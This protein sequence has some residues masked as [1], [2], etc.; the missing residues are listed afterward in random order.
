MDDN[1]L[2]HEIQQVSLIQQKIIKILEAD[3]KE[4]NPISA[5]L[6]DLELMNVATK[7]ISEKL[8]T[9]PVTSEQTF[10]WIMH[11]LRTPLTP[12]LAYTDLL[13]SNQ[14]GE[15]TDQQREKTKIIAA[16][17]K[18]LA[19]TVDSLRDRLKSSPNDT[20][21]EIRE[22]KQEKEILQKINQNLEKNQNPHQSIYAPD[23]DKLE[24]EQEKLLLSKTIKAVE[25]KN[26]R[27]GKRHVVIV[28]VFV[29]AIGAIVAGYSVYV[30]QLTGEQFRV[31]V[32][33]ANTGYVIQNL[34][35]DTIDTWLSWRLVSGAALHVNVPNSEKYP[36]KI[37]LVR[38]VVESEKSI[39]IDDS[40]LHKGFSGATSTYYV[41]WAGALKRASEEQTQYFIPSS[42]QVIES[43]TGEGDITITLTNDKSGD[44]YSGFTRSIADDSQNQI[45]KSEIT[46]YEADKLSDEEFKAILRHEL[47][48]AFGLAHSTAPEDLMHHTIMTQFPYISDCDIDAIVKLYDG[49]KTSQ[50]ICEK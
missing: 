38:E 47:G 34:R 12:I 40:L 1:H 14:F 36:E 17:I 22:L 27:L 43:K 50:V 48:H 28:A 23:H 46:I 44:G 4:E 26:L 8:E 49:G 19:A 33:P 10:E 31:P 25:E 5:A 30:V 41:G 15:L 35:G 18:K 9:S 24:L 37:E 42:L 29:A 32:N 11:N 7:K 16:N 13:L 39:E 45:L 20:N 6:S 21:Q 3:N 2:I